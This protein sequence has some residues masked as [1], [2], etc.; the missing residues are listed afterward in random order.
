MITSYGVYS[1]AF[2]A[3]ALACKFINVI[4]TG[5]LSYAF[6]AIHLSL[7]TALVVGTAY[8]FVKLI[9]KQYQSYSS[10]K[11][12]WT[13]LTEK[14]ENFFQHVRMNTVQ[15]TLLVLKIA[16]QI[17]FIYSTVQKFKLLEYAM[18]DPNCIVLYA[19]RAGSMLLNQA[20]YLG[21]VVMLA[22]L[23]YQNIYKRSPVYQNSQIGQLH[24]SPF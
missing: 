7:V 2:R 16:L 24:W 10:E 22:E 3:V 17:F 9:I 23:L 19:K 20:K 21:T 12:L 6:P 8:D 11:G 14:I 13:F 5:A 4:F 18:Q 1:V 15:S